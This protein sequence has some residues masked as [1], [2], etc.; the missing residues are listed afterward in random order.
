MPAPE[1][2]PVAEIATESPFPPGSLLPFAMPLLQLLGRLRGLAGEADPAA[3]RDRTEA[4]LRSFETRALEGGIGPDLVRRAHYALCDSLDRAVLNTPWGAGSAWAARTMVTAFHPAIGPNRFTDALHHAEA[5]TTE[6]GPVLEIMLLCLSLGV[7][8]EAERQ[9]AAASLAPSAP[10]AELSPQWRGV[11]APFQPRRRP[12]VP[13]WVAAAAALAAA[14]GLFVWVR[15]GLDARGDALF[16]AMID[17]PPARMPQIVR[18]PAPPLPPPPPPTIPTAQ[19]RLASRVGA[20]DS[21]G[22]RGSPGAPILRVPERALFAPNSAT[23][24]P[25]AAAVLQRAAAALQPEH[26]TV[27]VIGYTDDR[28]VRT[29]AFPSAFKLTAA[30]AQAVRA[31]LAGLL[32]AIT[33]AAEGRGAADPVAPNKTD[34]DREQNRRIDLVLEGAEP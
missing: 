10:A 18:D 21:I 26:G 17:A 1:P 24:L 4:A 34:A 8:A 12:K 6:F 32:P 31:A 3:L 23:L 33:I 11:D 27:R 2:A 20:N 22:V 5:R 9:K 29:V 14:G 13:I 7:P 15:T 28:P 16:A 30:R 19:D 25:G